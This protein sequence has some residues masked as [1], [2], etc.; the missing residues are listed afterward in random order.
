MLKVEGR[1]ATGPAAQ[2]HSLALLGLLAAS[3]PGGMSREKLVS[4]LWPDVSETTARNRLSTH[5]HR[6]RRELGAEAF[7]SGAGALALD[8]AVVTSDV[9]RF[10]AAVEAGDSRAAVEAYGGPFMDGFALKGAVEFEHWLEAR[11]EAFRRDYHEVLVDLA[12]RAVEQ[13]AWDEAVRWWRERA[14]DDPLDAGV[15]VALMEALWS[16]GNPAGAL[17]AARL[18]GE[19][20]E[21]ELGARPAD[22]VRELERRIRDAPAAP[23]GGGRSS[24]PDPRRV[25]VLPFDRLGTGQELEIFA[26]G[27]HQDLLTRLARV[28]GLQVISR[29]S[30]MQ[31]RDGLGD[32]RGIGRDLGAG[33]VVDGGVQQAGE[34]IRLHVRLVDVTEDAPRW[35][36]TY[37]RRLTAAEVFD[38]QSELAGRIVESLR[39]E[40]DGDGSGRPLRPWVPTG[41]L[42]AYRLWA[43]GRVR[44]D[45][46]TETGMRRAEALFREALEHDPAYT[47]AWV[48]LAD[49][50]ALLYEYGHADAAIL[51]EA[52]AVARRATELDPGLGEARTSRG[53][54]HEARHQG[55]EAIREYRRAVELQ[56]SY[57]DAYNWMSWTYQNLGMAEAA[58]E[59]SRRAV[60]LNPLAPEVVGNLS[61]TL[62][63]TGDPE[64]ALRE[65]RRARGLEPAEPTAVFYEALALQRLGR[66]DEAGELLEGLEVLWAGEGPRCTLA[67]VH[68]ERGDEARAREILEALEAERDWGA[69]GLVRAAMEDLDGAFRCFARITRFPYWPA[70]PLHHHFPDQLS[71]FRADPRFSDLLARVRRFW[72]LEPDGSFA[73]G[74]GASMAPSA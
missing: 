72:G 49:A 36:E 19:L 29:A 74:S 70:I 21:R 50:L 63:M 68:L 6:L 73:E 48:G 67:L 18:H 27:L 41:N 38:I 32:P 61:V 52:E 16:A 59:A 2:R 12:R 39:G 15:T 43:E 24:E 17:D 71:A 62:L 58:V 3:G 13:E 69:S 55:P 66:L 45:E 35:A 26:G 1:A 53:L 7:V 51:A 20:M 42:E 33:T 4:Y 10:M 47:L 40:L 34:R 14:R 11:R 30:V 31:Y 65:A 46:R 5:L 23:G 44:M 57:A 8:A 54:I 37:D 64:R 22:E 60:P 56:P 28:G 9:A 25:A